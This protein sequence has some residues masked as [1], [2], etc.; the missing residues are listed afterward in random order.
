MWELKPEYRYY[1]QE[2]AEENTNDKAKDGD[3]D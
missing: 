3:S 2:V 1:K